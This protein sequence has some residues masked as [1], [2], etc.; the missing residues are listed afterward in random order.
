MVES[1]LDSVNLG[2]WPMLSDS[3][4]YSDTEIERTMSILIIYKVQPFIEAIVYTDE[5]NAS[6][7]TLQVN[8]FI[9]IFI[10]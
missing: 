7:Y 5:K 3:W 9:D 6:V 2:K 4:I 10:T 8:R 1:F